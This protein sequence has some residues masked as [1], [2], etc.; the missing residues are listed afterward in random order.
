MLKKYFEIGTVEE[1]KESRE[2]QRGKKPKHFY[3]KYGKHKWKRKENG[4]IDDFAW[5]SEF[6][7][8]VSCERCYKDVCVH[9][10]PDY[11]ELDDCKE[12]HWNC[13]KCEKRVGWKSKYCDCGQKLDWSE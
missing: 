3:R 7:N 8:G 6:H 13:P 11:N 10:D 2:K 5:A 4:E 12:E 9:C 1:C